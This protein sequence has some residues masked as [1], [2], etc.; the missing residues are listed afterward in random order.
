MPCYL[1]YN[2]LH[3]LPGYCGSS[4]MTSSSSSLSGSG[5]GSGSGVGDVI[6]GSGVGVR[7]F[8]GLC[9]CGFVYNWFW[10]LF[11]VLLLFLNS[12]CVKQCKILTKFFIIDNNLHHV[13]SAIITC[14]IV[15][16]SVHC[17][18]FHSS[19]FTYIL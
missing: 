9:F 1:F 2:S 14:Y 11:L 13:T 4:S 17:V 16:V 19:N 6:I 10:I 5:S 18:L 15:N 7:R 8:L 12:N 3:K